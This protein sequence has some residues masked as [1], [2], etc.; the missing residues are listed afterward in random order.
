VV[1]LKAECAIVVM[2]EAE[3]AVVVMLK[4]EITNEVLLEVFLWFFWRLTRSSLCC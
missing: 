3:S 4:T 2:L 1:L